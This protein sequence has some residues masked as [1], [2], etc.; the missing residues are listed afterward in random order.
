MASTA[1]VGSGMMRDR[2]S[3]RAHAHSVGGGVVLTY[4]LCQYSS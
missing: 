4:P 1:D 2:R 3:A